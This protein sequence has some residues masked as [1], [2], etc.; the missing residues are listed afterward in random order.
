MTDGAASWADRLERARAQ[1]TGQG[2]EDVS[3]RLR[4]LAAHVLSC[5]LLDIERHAAAIPTPEQ[6][7]EFTAGVERLA[8]DEPVQYVMGETDFMGLRIRCDRRALIPRP[9]TE[10][11]VECAEEVLHTLPG[12][13]VVVDVGTG[14]GCIA[15]ALAL[16]VPRAQVR[17]T[18]IS[19]QALALARE[20]ALALGAAVHFS[21]A[22]MLEGQAAA[23][24]DLVVSNPPYVASRDCQHLPAHVRNFEPHLA[25][26]GGA[27]G[28]QII[29]RL[30]SQAARV[31]VPLGRFIIEIGE[32][33]ADAV[34]EMV[35]P[36]NMF[37]LET[38]KS[39]YAGR[40]RL[41]V[42]RR[43]PSSRPAP[44]C[45]GAEGA[46]TAF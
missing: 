44:T 22:D 19:P 33:Q 37:N 13:P 8:A 2:V 20:N 35:C 1:L 5:G 11:L 30:V 45:P 17:A 18:D 9:E 34:R 6:A 10:L 46:S 25:L 29:S 36:K 14:T 21:Q 16:R 40:V 28:L 15:C 38:L 24:V 4:W 32:D 39:D 12:R 31:I 43:V 23:S 26:D 42:A 7:R 41:A 3:S 27:D